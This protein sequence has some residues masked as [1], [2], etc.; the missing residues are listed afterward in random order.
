MRLFGLGR[1][2]VAHDK[3]RFSASYLFA[4][5]LDTHVRLAWSFFFGLGYIEEFVRV[6]LESIPLVRVLSYY[7]KSPFQ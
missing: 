7:R 2:Q 3:V 1:S 4:M 6:D 5:S